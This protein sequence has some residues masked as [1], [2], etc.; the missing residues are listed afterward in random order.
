MK[1]LGELDKL[2]NDQLRELNILIV[3]LLKNRNRQLTQTFRPGDR[4]GWYDRKRGMK[5]G[6]VKETLQKNV[7]VLA[8]DG[9]MWRVSGTLLQ[10]Q[11]AR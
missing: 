7:R 2:S 1:E 5:Y 4:V 9:V 8:D 10:R 11:A 6:V 3:S